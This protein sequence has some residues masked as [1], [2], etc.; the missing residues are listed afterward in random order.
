MD[1]ELCAWTYKAFLCLLLEN[2]FFKSVL[3]GQFLLYLKKVYQG[4]W[5]GKSSLTAH[6]PSLLTL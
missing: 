5:E 3:V 2:R 4:G 1:P 6:F